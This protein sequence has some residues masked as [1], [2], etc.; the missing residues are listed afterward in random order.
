[1]TLASHFD[2]ILAAYGATVVILGTLIVWVMLDYR[3]LKR[4]LADFEDEGVTRR[5]DTARSLL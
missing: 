5:S 2:F 1:M 4:T 3:A